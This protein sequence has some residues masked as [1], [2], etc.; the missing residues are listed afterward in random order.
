[1]IWISGLSWVFEKVCELFLDW[2]WR[3]TIYIIDFGHRFMDQLVLQCAELGQEHAN[4][5]HVAQ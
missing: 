1:M 3:L 2:M 4:E 5:P